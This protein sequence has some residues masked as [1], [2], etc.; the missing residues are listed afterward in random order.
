MPDSLPETQ[1]IGVR[2]TGPVLNCARMD[3]P[4][5]PGMPWYE[6][7]DA[8]AAGDFAMA[9]MFIQSHPNLTATLNGI[10]KTVLLFLA[11]K[12]PPPASLGYTTR[13]RTSIVK[14][15]SASRRGLKSRNWAIAICC[16]GSFRPASTSTQ[17]IEKGRGCY[18]FYRA[19]AKTICSNS[20]S[21]T[22]RTK[23]EGVMAML[24]KNLSP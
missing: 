21:T 23:M 1:D 14:M 22:S 10:G 19:W 12:T 7:R 6:L 2:Q 17:R 18:R 15:T 24:E 16:C 4:T 11:A 13:A 9:A 20:S 3:S 8:I 5:P